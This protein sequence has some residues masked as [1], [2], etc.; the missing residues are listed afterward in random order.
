MANNVKEFRVKKFKVN[1][2]EIDL[3]LNYICYGKLNENKDNLII[4]PTRFAGNHNDQDYL[5]GNNQFLNPEKFF[6]CIP[7]MFGNGIS[8][9][10]SN[11]EGELKGPS[12]PRLSINDNVVLQKKLI[13]DVFGVNKVYMVI[14][15][16]M[17]GQQAYE[18]GAFYP[19]HV[20]RIVPI[21]AHAKTT[22]HT[23]VFLEG[24]Y[25]ALTS[26]PNWKNGNYIKQPNKGKTTMARV[27][28]GWAH[29]QNWYREKLYLK[30]GYKNPTDVLLDYWDE[31]YYKKD[32]NDLIHMIRTWQNHDI[33]RNSKY[34]N[35]YIS[36]LKNIKAQVLL[37][38]GINDLYF[39]P[40]DNQIEIK[41]LKNA[42]LS[43][44]RSDYGH[45]AGAGK[46][47]KDLKFINEQLFKYF[48]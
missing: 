18:W 40:E 7:N 20:D 38:P 35:N 27:W 41:H 2:Q 33:S 19:N 37:M 47:K 43:V 28:A 46:S 9:S 16:S 25:E 3:K 1:N 11:S 15:W 42:Q 39:P 21:C 6:I 26:D 13:E 36:A 12:F 34:K 22:D 32:A 5:I 14:G 17:G 10:P 4:F 48:G 8:S 30:E 23:F 31:I 44:I 29:G 24:M 45:Y